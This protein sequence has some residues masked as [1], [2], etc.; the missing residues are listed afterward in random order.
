MSSYGNSL[1][2]TNVS[3]QRPIKMN[4]N[5]GLA[6]GT[7]VA[8]YTVEINE[9]NVVVNGVI[10]PENDPQHKG[11]LAEHAAYQIVFRA[12]ATPVPGPHMVITIPGTAS[13]SAYKPEIEVNRTESSQYDA[14]TGENLYVMRANANEYHVIRQARSGNVSGDILVFVR[15]SVN[16]D[17]LQPNN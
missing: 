16:T 15:F 4:Y 5:T 1:V 13:S 7:G 12:P 14:A 6:T 3:L 17:A 2:A 9:T 10:P 8:P 11:G